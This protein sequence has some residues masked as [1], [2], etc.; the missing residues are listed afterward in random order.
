MQTTIKSDKD[1]SFLVWA[2]ISRT[3]GQ[4]GLEGNKAKGLHS[5]LASAMPTPTNTRPRLLKTE[6]LRACQQARIVFLTK[7]RCMRY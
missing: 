1:D 3:A 7:K 4:K 2:F 5:G 6:I